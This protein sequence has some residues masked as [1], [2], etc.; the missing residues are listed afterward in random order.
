MTGLVIGALLFAASLGDNLIYDS[1]IRDD[2]KPTDYEKLTEN[3]KRGRTHLAASGSGFFIT[4]NGYILTNCHVIDGAKEVVIIRSGTAYMANVVAKNKELDLGLL[5]I[6]L[7]PRATNGTYVIKGIPT[8]PSL[9]FSDGCKV[10][11]TV[12]AIG[13]PKSDILGYEPKVTRGIVNSLT[14]FEGRKSIFQMDAGI[15]HGNSGGP[16]VDEY[17]FVV[18]VA[19]ASYTR[20]VSAN[21]NYAVNMESVR[22]FL[23]KDIKVSAGVPGRRVPPEKMTQRIIDSLVFILIYN[24]GACERI[25][26]T[27]VDPDDSQKRERATQIRKALLDAKLLKIRKDWSGLR[28][29]TD[30]ILECGEYAEARELNDLARDELGLHLVVLAEA[31]GRD[32]VATIK[33]IC[34]FKDDGEVECGKPACLYGGKIRRGFDV[35]AK[36]TYEDDEWSWV[37]DLKC[38]YDWHGTKE[39]RVVLKHIGKKRK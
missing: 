20:S 11:Q 38:V 16:V 8:V 28:E 26:S 35:E 1:F 39:K 23:P 25:S 37:G 5:K 19:V 31:D 14:G 4:Q 7:F 32:V 2:V 13:F 30:G 24:E 34:G 22:K 10:G 17:G 29:L 21:I 9:E 36:L 18:G 15:D 3:A 6:N 12:Y 33:P 27:S